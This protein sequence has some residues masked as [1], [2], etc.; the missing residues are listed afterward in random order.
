MWGTYNHGVHYD[1]ARKSITVILV[2]AYKVQSSDSF[3]LQRA[4]CKLVL[5]YEQ[6]FLGENLEENSWQ[7]PFS[8]H[9]LLWP[10]NSGAS[11][12]SLDGLFVEGPAMPTLGNRSGEEVRISSSAALSRMH[13]LILHCQG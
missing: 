11:P 6:C 5:T 13:S 10:S 9:N 12:S 3:C 7:V 2:L 1:K 4:S 8:S